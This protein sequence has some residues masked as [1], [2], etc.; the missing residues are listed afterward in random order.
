MLVVICV[1][2]RKNEVR[3]EKTAT[4]QSCKPKSKEK[5]PQIYCLYYDI[6]SVTLGHL[7]IGIAKYLPTRHQCK[8][9]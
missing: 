2:R 8:A 4:K 7:E 6:V 3:F 5:Q 9:S 1:S